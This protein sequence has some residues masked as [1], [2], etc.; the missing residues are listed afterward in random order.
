[1]DERE[2]RRTRAEMELVAADE[3]QRRTLQAH[4]RADER[5][6]RD[7]Q[8]E[9]R[10]VLAQPE[11]DRPR[12]HATS[13]IGRP[14]RFAATI[15]TCCSGAAGMSRSSASTNESSSECRSARLWRRSKPIVEAGLAD[16]P[17]PQTDPE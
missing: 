17:R 4:H 8:R 6:D 14:V 12:A 7:Q 1:D 15:A 3:R 13:A 16:S 5:V 9:L 10:R 11:A 2:H